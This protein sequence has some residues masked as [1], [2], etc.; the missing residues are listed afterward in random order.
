MSYCRFSSAN[1]RSD[2]YVFEH[3]YGGW[4]IYVAGNRVVGDIPEEGSLDDIDDFVKKHK[5]V[6]DFLGSAERE[7]I[8]LPYA[9]EGINMPTAKDAAEKLRELE[10]LGYFIPEGVIDELETE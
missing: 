10:K 9:G 2:V 1:W 7:K 3:C 4:Q 6:M 8:D 5:V